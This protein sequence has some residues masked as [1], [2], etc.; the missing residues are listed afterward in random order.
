[1]PTGPLSWVT[2]MEGFEAPSYVLDAPVAQFVVWGAY[3]ID[4]K[5]WGA[6]PDADGSMDATWVEHFMTVVGPE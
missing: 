6:L 3:H 5:S 1:M 4:G 2:F